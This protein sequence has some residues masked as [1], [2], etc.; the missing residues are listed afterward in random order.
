MQVFKYE[1]VFVTRNDVTPAKAAELMNNAMESLEGTTDYVY[2]INLVK[3]VDTLHGDIIWDA[4]N[5]QSWEKLKTVQR[6]W[7]DKAKELARKHTMD[8]MK[9]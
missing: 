2:R 7:N 4:L 5:K 1:L 6:E 9:Y 3:R 8:L